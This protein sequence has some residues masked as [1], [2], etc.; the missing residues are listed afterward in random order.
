MMACSTKKQASG[1]TKSTFIDA[2]NL[3]SKP[4]VSSFVSVDEENARMEKSYKAKKADPSDS[5][6]V[7]FSRTGCFGTCPIFTL[8][9]YTSGHAIYQGKN[10]VQMKGVYE[11]NFNLADIK[12]IFN[13]AEQISFLTLEDSYDNMGISDVPSAITRLND[14]NYTKQVLNRYNGPKELNQLENLIDELILKQNWN[15]IQ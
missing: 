14:G 13:M 8:S 7:Q 2:S 12:S 4:P 11:A 6:M 3:P 9:I 1:E 15:K 5:L 10:F